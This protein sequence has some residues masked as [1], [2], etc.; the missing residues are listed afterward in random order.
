MVPEKAR[1]KRRPTVKELPPSAG[2]VHSH[3]PEP[4]TT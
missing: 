2:H 1:K 4:V 3:I